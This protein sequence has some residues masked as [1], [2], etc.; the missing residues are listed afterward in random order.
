MITI[1]SS[2]AQDII[3]DGMSTSVREGGPARFIT[4][5]LERYERPY[6][7]VTGERITVQIDLAREESIVRTGTRI[8]R[9]ACS[10]PVIVSTILREFDLSSLHVPFAIDVQGYV[11]DGNTLGGKRRMSDPALKGAWLVKATRREFSFVDKRFLDPDAILLISDGAR[12]F[13]VRGA[14]RFYM[15]AS[16]ITVSDTIGAGDTLFASFALAVLEGKSLY[17]AA[18]QAKIDTESFLCEQVIL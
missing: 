6:H 8:A 16:R 14:N 15:P 12:G 1:I 18:A 7:I 2:Y 5:I 4:R 17:E 11:R 13:E 9:T 10:E 3:Y